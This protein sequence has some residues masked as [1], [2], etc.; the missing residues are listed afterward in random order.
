MPLPPAATRERL[1]TRTLSCE[2]FRRSDGL[3]DLEARLTDHKDRRYTLSTGTWEPGEPVHDLWIRVT[4]D[5]HYEIRA[6]SACLDAYP[7]PDGCDRIAPDYA[8][9]VGANLVDGFRRTV[10]ERLGGVRGCSHL[11]ELVLF[12]PTAAIQTFATF[13]PE[14][15]GEDKPFQLDRCHALETKTPTVRRY[16]PRWYR[17]AA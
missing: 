15:S 4:I 12:L 16:Y 6:V 13:L 8:R 14:M 2:G 11:T 3:F 5:R 1:H 10:Q 17:G 9:L 7:Y